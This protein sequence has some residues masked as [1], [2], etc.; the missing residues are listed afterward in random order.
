MGG[1]QP[2]DEEQPWITDYI[3]RM[4]QDRKF[5]EDAYHR[6]QSEKV[7]SW[8]DT[9]VNAIEKPVSVQEFTKELEKHQHHHH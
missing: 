9:K 3:N 1:M 5:V 2:M 6:I 7:F 4:M 8:A